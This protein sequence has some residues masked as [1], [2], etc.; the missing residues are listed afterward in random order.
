MLSKDDIFT[1]IQARLNTRLALVVGTGS[2]MSIHPDFGMWALENHLDSCIPALI[3]GDSQ[4]QSDWSKVKDKRVSGC[5][6]ENALNEVK[7]EF[8]LNSIIR[9]TGKHVTNVS[10]HTLHSVHTGTIPIKALLNK[11]RH[12]LSPSHPLLDIITPNYDLIIESAL[13]QCN[14]PYTDGFFGEYIKSF[15]WNEAKHNFLRMSETSKTKG[16]RLG[17]ANPIPFVKLHKVHGSLN[18]FIQGDNIVR[19]DT[20]SYFPDPGHA[21][22]FIITPGESKHKRIVQNRSFYAE[23]D[24]SIDDVNTFLFVGYGFNDI[25][26]DKKICGDIASRG[27]NA[28]IVTKEITSEKGQTLFNNPNNIIIVDNN[29]GGAKIFYNNYKIDIPEPIWLIDKFTQEIL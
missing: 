16:S 1:E 3:C 11:L 17:K 25:D 4:A 2:S 7:S 6:F 19:I 21:D 26:I 14:I 20:L 15:N 18:Y 10:I 28:I 9:E 5:D 23:M 13:S 29:S 12:L 22:R 8:L 27:K 24:N